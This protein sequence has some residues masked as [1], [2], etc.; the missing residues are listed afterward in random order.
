MVLN[1][2]S[3][4][5]ARYCMSI[6]LQFATGGAS[7]QS[8]TVEDADQFAKTNCPAEHREHRLTNTSDPET[9]LSSCLAFAPVI[10]AS[11]TLET[12]R[13]PVMLKFRKLRSLVCMGLLAWSATASATDAVDLKVGDA[14]PVFEVTDD[15][16]ET[17]KSE[18]HVGKKILVVYFYPA[19]MTGGCTKQACG[20]R[21]D[22]SKLSDEN[23]EV[24]GISGDSASNHQLFK[25]AHK[26]NFTLLADTDGKVADAFG[27]P[28]TRE[29]K[30]VKATIDGKEEV[31]LRSVT[32]KRWTFVVGLDGK[33]ASKNTTVV[34]AD[35]SKAIMKVVAELQKDAK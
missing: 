33:V 34:A 27:V 25:K 22:L 7:L 9:L 10:T 18:E 16:G 1:L 29:E 6:A 17:W 28:V 15:K 11:V 3:R 4:P 23:V 12:S 32:P 26:L 13:K 31:L 8:R 20:F 19:D 14:A 5:F 24:V 35:D 21:D 2:R 30:S